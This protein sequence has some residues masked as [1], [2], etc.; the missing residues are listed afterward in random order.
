MFEKSAATNDRK[1]IVEYYLK[2]DIR[3]IKKFSGSPKY[4]IWLGAVSRE[5]N[6]ILNPAVSSMQIMVPMSFTQRLWPNDAR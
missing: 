5:L 1:V 2:E 4:F 3:S 6:A